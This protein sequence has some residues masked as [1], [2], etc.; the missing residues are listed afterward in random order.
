[1]EQAAAPIHIAWTFV[2]VARSVVTA[3]LPEDQ[4]DGQIDRDQIHSSLPDTSSFAQGPSR[5]C[6]TAGLNGVSSHRVAVV[7]AVS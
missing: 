1:M 3:C 6:A 4:N 5:H 2:D 7:P